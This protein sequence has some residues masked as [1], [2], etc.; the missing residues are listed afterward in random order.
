MA[1]TV[2][3]LTLDDD[4]EAF[5]RIVVASY[6]ELPGHPADADYDKEL[7]DVAAR[8]R[9]ATVLGAVEGSAP[10]GCVTYVDGAGSPYAER[11]EDGE[12]SFRMLAVSPA[13]AGPRRGRGAGARLPR[14]RRRVGRSA[15]FIHSGSW[16]GGAHRL[17]RRLGFVV[18]ARVS[19]RGSWWRRGRRDGI[20]VAGH[21]KVRLNENTAG[22]VERRA[23]PLDDRRRLIPR[24]PDDGVRPEVIPAIQIDGVRLDVDD[25]CPNA[26]LDAQALEV[27]L[28]P[29]GEILRE[30]REDTRPG[31]DENDLRVAGVDASEFGAHGAAG[32]LWHYARHLAAVGSARRRQ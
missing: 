26:Y 3:R 18:P 23:K 21:R 6:H 17:Y 32:D 7:L 19:R 31:L 11:L 13:A 1:V 16:M 15:V 22:S 20:R 12:A 28:R 2:R 14:P 10:L 24:R 4:H 30:R 25:A 27:F 5:G 29:G 9:S 8:V